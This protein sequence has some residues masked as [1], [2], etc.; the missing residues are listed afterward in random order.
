MR[1]VFITGERVYLRSLSEKDVNQ[2]YISWLNDPDVCRFNS[3][4][5]YPYTRAKALEYVRAAQLSRSDLVLAVV[6]RRGHRHIGNISLQAI[7]QI[8]RNAE[9]AVLMGDKRYWGKG[10]AKE[11]SLLM[12]LHGF[13]EMN[14]H[15]IYCGT[16]SHNLPMQ[17]LA[18]QLGMKLEGRRREAFYKSGE[19][20]DILEYGVLRREFKG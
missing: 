3:H 14:L 7:S 12:L 5:V 20:L 15:R 4:H 1:D 8:S 10:Y 2:A 13:N 16:S 18:K 19:F 9:Y 6:T 11:A 17:K